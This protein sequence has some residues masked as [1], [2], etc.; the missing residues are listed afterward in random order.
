MHPGKGLPSAQL[1][2][3]ENDELMWEKQV[4]RQKD[5]DSEIKHIFFFFFEKMLFRNVLSFELIR[6]IKTNIHTVAIWS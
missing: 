5:V 2:E 3:T 1:D 4:K 6:V